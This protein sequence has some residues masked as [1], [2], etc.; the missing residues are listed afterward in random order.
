MRTFST[1]L[2]NALDNPERY[3]FVLLTFN[4][5]G[6][7]YGIWTGQSE[8]EYNSITYRG[9]GS[10]IDVPDIEVNGDG[11]IAEMTLSL[12]ESPEKG[13]T[14]DVLASWFST[15]WHMQSVTMEL[16]FRDPD[17]GLPIDT[18][19]LFDGVMPQAP[20]RRGEGKFRLDVR[21]VSNA[22][23]MSE[24]G[25]KYRNAQTQALIDD[26]D[27]ALNDI[28]IYGESRVKELKWG[29]ASG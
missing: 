8:V 10:I 23:K 9:G 19:V 2:Q 15:D 14:V 28:G 21:C 5:G 12:S 26:T 7:I 17:T 4:L 1:D 22:Y 16:G 3:G 18:F 24:A 25:G 13:I 27:T 6:V 20:L 11:S 29:Q